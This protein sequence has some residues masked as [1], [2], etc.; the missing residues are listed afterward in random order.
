MCTYNELPDKSI[1]LWFTS[2]LITSNFEELFGVI[3]THV[4]SSVVLLRYTC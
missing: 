4:D 3:M 1:N 2:S